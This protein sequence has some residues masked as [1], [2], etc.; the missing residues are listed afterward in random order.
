MSSKNLKKHNSNTNMYYQIIS[1]VINNTLKSKYIAIFMY[2]IE[3]IPLI[4]YATDVSIIS[5]EHA[6]LKPLSIYQNIL[7]FVIKYIIPE[8]YMKSYVLD[9]EKNTKSVFYEQNIILLLNY[10]VYGILLLTI[11][12]TGFIYVYVKNNYHKSN[13]ISS[14]TQLIFNFSCNYVY[15]VYKVLL[16]H[17]IN[18]LLYLIINIDK[19]YS[20]NTNNSSNKLINTKINVLN[21][22]LTVLNS[23]ILLAYIT[24]SIFYNRI[25]VNYVYFSKCNLYPDFNYENTYLMIEK[26]ILGLIY[27]FSDKLKYTLNMCFYMLFLCFCVT[28]LKNNCKKFT[29][30]N[31]YFC[32]PIKFYFRVFCCL[33]FFTIIL[34]MYMTFQNIYLSILINILYALISFLA[35]LKVHYNTLNS[36]YDFNYIKHQYN[37]NNF[38]KYKNK[39]CYSSNNNLAHSL[40]AKNNYKNLNYL[41]HKMP[42]QINKS[43]YKDYNNINI[44]QNKNLDLNKKNIENRK[45][46]HKSSNNNIEYDNIDDEK[47]NIDNEESSFDISSNT[48]IQETSN[49]CLD[50]SDL[51]NLIFYFSKLDCN[52]KI[53]YL[54][55][56]I[57]KN[58]N[59]NHNN[60]FH[61]Y[62]NPINYEII[63]N[64]AKNTENKNV[65]V[66]NLDYLNFF[67]DEEENENIIGLNNIES[68]IVKAN[69]LNFKK[70]NYLQNNKDINLIALDLKKIFFYDLSIYIPH[71]NDIEFKICYD[72]I[73]I[74]YLENY[75]GTIINYNN[76]MYSSITYLYS[77]ITIFDYCLNLYKCRSNFKENINIIFSEKMLDFSNYYKEFEELLNKLVD[78]KLEFLT[79][80]NNSNSVCLKFDVISRFSKRFGELKTKT[81]DILKLTKENNVNNYLYLPYLIKFY[82]SIILKD[83]FITKEVVISNEKI[84]EDFSEESNVANS[85]NNNRQCFLTLKIDQLSN[86]WRINNFSNL[87]PK[88]LNMNVSELKEANINILIPSF[89]KG[90]YHNIINKSTELSPSCY[91]II[92]PINNKKYI[93]PFKLESKI[94]PTINLELYILNSLKKEIESNNTIIF[95]NKNNGN[96]IIAFTSNCYQYFGLTPDLVNLISFDFNE[97]FNIQEELKINSVINTKLSMKSLYSYAKKK[98]K[99]LRKDSIAK[100]LFNKRFDISDSKTINSKPEYNDLIKKD[101]ICYLKDIEYSLK[102]SLHKKSNFNDSS[103]NEFINNEY[104]NNNNNNNKGFISSSKTDN[105]NYKIYKIQIVKINKLDSKEI[106]INSEINCNKDISNSKAISNNY[107]SIITEDN[108]LEKF[109]LNKKN[110]KGKV[111]NIKNLFK[112]IIIFNF[113]LLILSLCQ[114]FVSLINK[115]NDESYLKNFLIYYNVIYRELTS[116]ISIQKIVYNHAYNEYVINN[117][118]IN[119]NNYN[120]NIKNSLQDKYGNITNIINPNNASTNNNGYQDSLKINMDELLYVI[121]ANNNDT[122]SLINEI[123]LLNTYF[124]YEKLLLFYNLKI[125]IPVI[126]YL[127][128]SDNSVEL[129]IDFDNL[130]LKSLKD[131][132]SIT[133][134]KNNYLQLNNIQQNSYT[135]NTLIKFVDMSSNLSI[136]IKNLQLI[137]YYEMILLRLNII[138]PEL[139]PIN[140]NYKNF[141][142]YLLID[143]NKT[144]INDNKNILNE[145]DIKLNSLLIN[146][147]YDFHSQVLA[148]FNLINVIKDGKLKSNYYFVLI[149]FIIMVILKLIFI[150]F[151]L[152]K[153]YNIFVEFKSNVSNI[154]NL[155][156]QSVSKDIKILNVFKR[157][158]VEV[159]SKHDFEYLLKKSES[160]NINSI[161]KQLNLNIKINNNNNNKLLK[162]DMDKYNNYNKKTINTNNS[163]NNY[164][165]YNNY[166]ATNRNLIIDNDNIG[167]NE[168]ELKKKIIEVEQLKDRQL[169]VLDMESLT[170]FSEFIFS[171]T[172]SLA[173]NIAYYV[174][175]LL[176]NIY[177]QNSLFNIENYLIAKTQSNIHLFESVSY[178]QIKLI[179]GYVLDLDNKINNKDLESIEANIFDKNNEIYN[180]YYNKIYEAKYYYKK[181]VN[182]LFVNISTFENNLLKNYNFAD[183][184]YEMNNNKNNNLELF[185]S[186]NDNTILDQQ[187]DNMEYLENL[188]L[189]FKDIGINT[190]SSSI[191]SNYYNLGKYID[192]FKL[193]NKVQ[194]A[195]I[196]NKENFYNIYYKFFSN[197]PY[198]FNKNNFLT[199]N[200]Y[201]LNTYY[202]YATEKRINDLIKEIQYIINI[203][204]YINIGLY[205]VVLLIDA[206]TILYLLLR[207]IKRNFNLIKDINDM[208]CS[209]I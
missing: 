36:L 14:L 137:K 179:N 80:I 34:S 118:Y 205:T 144:N 83:P 152:F 44:N 84:S 104:D 63:I 19:S 2:I 154:E 180:L 95:M 169:V 141:K 193:Q 5:I 41:L 197:N 158:L 130:V 120:E 91:K 56:L 148:T 175:Y 79:F 156:H 209:I 33:Q 45:N 145:F 133:L 203:L 159:F 64:L 65:H 18:I 94:L 6:Y 184:I 52:Q 85:N 35:T 67:N 60:F 150:T 138:S 198:N 188:F 134:D 135:F 151:L 194:I 58:M 183:Y 49:S 163:I 86:C 20:I 3:Y 170:I 121:N 202:R 4:Y 192:I 136:N 99:N 70:E 13:N 11:I 191:I 124:D 131:D 87:F 31:N 57:N 78:F 74:D 127:I 155:S 98:F 61:S 89:L 117:P 51:F 111:M 115:T 166:A 129:E 119:N 201:I 140:I 105:Y 100:D 1:I 48:L 147:G 146:S 125:D 200:F 174:I 177:F 182:T 207:K 25:A 107:L 27:T 17:I 38:C 96:E 185:I 187:T 173:I 113:F 190:F 54:T 164:D 7:A 62:L 46:I 186:S 9:I 55:A 171:I 103:N 81:E 168:T 50:K 88:Y 93:I 101:T 22:I 26:I 43:S 82:H 208:I 167:L 71:T 28:Y 24:F 206:A 75:I 199:D 139:N 42:H 77:N 68:N 196:K 160:A 112:V 12:I 109:K 181:T 142:T 39:N 195:N 123:S 189:R 32:N 97:M 116:I 21:I 178:N 10:L 53:K 72:I 47:N 162:N 126:Q 73:Q 161:K 153:T 90:K 165:S 132:L 122:N 76:K 128:T 69:A 143:Y 37:I 114:I 149:F 29:Y 108:R 23:L 40:V 30:I 176:I 102:I 66:N 106:N 172:L 15:F 16:F 92:Y 110:R 157:S 59:Y 8:F 204:F